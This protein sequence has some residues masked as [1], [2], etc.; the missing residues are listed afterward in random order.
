MLLK[1]LFMAQILYG[2]VMIGSGWILR[3]TVSLREA[4]SHG[5]G[6]TGRIDMTA[7]PGDR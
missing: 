4:S 5:G 6:P 7:G 2:F 3:P 1:E